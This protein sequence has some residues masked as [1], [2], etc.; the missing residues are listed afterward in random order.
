MVYN[1]EAHLGLG[2]VCCCVFQPGPGSEPR[3]F[4]TGSIH[5]WKVETCTQGDV[6]AAHLLLCVRPQHSVAVLDCT[7][8]AL[9]HAA[10]GWR[11]KGTGVRIAVGEHKVAAAA[12]CSRSLDR[13]EGG[14]CKKY[15]PA[16]LILDTASSRADAPPLV[17]QGSTQI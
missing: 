8:A 7:A 13:G 12:A 16:D 5:S 14:E 3:V 17:G 2:D 1:V 10:H 9:Q 4:L 15:K 6:T 11:R